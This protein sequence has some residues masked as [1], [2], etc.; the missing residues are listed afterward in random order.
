MEVIALM[1]VVVMV[2]EVVVM[3]IGVLEVGVVR[4]M[5]VMGG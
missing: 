4:E 1:E 5:V 2:V 3:V